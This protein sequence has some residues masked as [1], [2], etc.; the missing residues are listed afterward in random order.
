MHNF[1]NNF[2]NFQL[3][4]VSKVWNDSQTKNY[5]IFIELPRRSKMIR[6]IRAKLL[7]CT[8]QRSA[9]CSVAWKH[10]G[11]LTENVGCQIVLH[12]NASCISPMMFFW[13][14]S[15]WQDNVFW[16]AT[17]KAAGRLGTTSLAKHINISHNEQPGRTKIPAHKRLRGRNG[18]VSEAEKRGLK[19]MNHW[20]VILL[21]GYPAVRQHFNAMAQ[22]YMS[23]TLKANS[24]MNDKAWAVKIDN[25]L[26]NYMPFVD[27][28]TWEKAHMHWKMEN[29]VT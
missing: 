21:S 16:K 25:G 3:H 27:V 13:L 9:P 10:S 4:R 28:I 19:N 5:G 1:K 26:D 20:F 17:K 22:W 18:G 7:F 2:N 12:K 11:Y 15:R 24:D 23:C 6:M 14:L 8:S 29:S